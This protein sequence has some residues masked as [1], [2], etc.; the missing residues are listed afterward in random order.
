MRN[1][2]ARLRRALVEGELV[3]AAAVVCFSLIN[4][5]RAALGDD[6]AGWRLEDSSIFPSLL[7]FLFFCCFSLFFRIE[8]F[9]FLFVISPE[10][11]EPLH[12]RHPTASSSQSARARA[13]LLLRAARRLL[14]CRCRGARR[15]PERTDVSGILLLFAMLIRS[16]LLISGSTPYTSCIES[17]SILETLI[18]SVKR[19]VH[20]PGPQSI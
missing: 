15:S 18:R 14:G 9:Q 7:Y 11:H 1:I 6:D 16:A 19:T 4:G 2:N 20:L 12:A 8:L 17:S 5:L 10:M 13:E 3:L